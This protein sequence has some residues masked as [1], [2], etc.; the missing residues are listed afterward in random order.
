[1][2]LFLVTLPQILHL[3]KAATILGYVFGG[4][5]G[6]LLLIWI[7]IRIPAVQNKLVHYATEQAS[8]TL[9]TE[10]NIGSVDFSPFNRFYLNDIL[11]R[12]QKKDT[13]LFAGSLKL[14][15][16][17]WFFVKDKITIH[18]F[19]LSDTYINT[20]RTDSNWNYKFI[21]TALSSDKPTTSQPSTVELDL[22]EIE[23]ANI[24]YQTIDKWRGEDQLISIKSFKLGAK[25][26]NIKQKKIEFD[27]ILVDQPF[28]SYINMKD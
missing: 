27:N 23:L 1:M 6:L 10:I 24:R 2:I 18:Y 4:L 26:F 20:N 21:I 5:I 19:G 9:K 8:K 13:L 15:I 17:D 7:L 25:Q 3:K 12:D 11:V 22:K 28:L 14:R 16:T